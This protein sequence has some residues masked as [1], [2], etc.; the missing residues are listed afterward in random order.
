M[1]VQFSRPPGNGVYIRA[2]YDAECVI[3]IY[4]RDNDDDTAAR[5]SD[6]YFT[7]AMELFWLHIF[8]SLV[9]FSTFKIHFRVCQSASF[10]NQKACIVDCA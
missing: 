8:Q 1:R 6:V 7:T 5:V 2:I 9:Y 3:G 10:L 4:L